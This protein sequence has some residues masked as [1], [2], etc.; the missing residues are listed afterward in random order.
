MVFW[1]LKDLCFLEEVIVSCRELVSISSRAVVS[2][3][4][5][6]PSPAVSIPP[7]RLLRIIMFLLLQSCTSH[8]RAAHLTEELNVN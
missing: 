1:D 2:S 5:S 8:L 7:D 4:N 3:V 6:P